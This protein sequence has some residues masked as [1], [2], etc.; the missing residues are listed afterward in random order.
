MSLN[1]TKIPYI[2]LTGVKKEDNKLLLEYKN[3]VLNHI[4]TIHASAQ[5]TLA[6]TASGVYLQKLFPELE[7]KA[8]P[9]LR[10]AKVKYTKPASKKIYAYPCAQEA[11][12]QKFKKQFAKRGRGVIEVSVEIRDVEE[13]STCRAVFN[14]FV[15]SLQGY[16]L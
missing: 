3:D 8:V 13:T 10:E 12:I 2:K 14:W 16:R 9:I 1:A 15:Q 6:E 4:E 7:G 11:N 5:F